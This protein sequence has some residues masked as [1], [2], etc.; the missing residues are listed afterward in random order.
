MNIFTK[1]LFGILILAIC[2]V[3]F[4]IVWQKKQVNTVV[5]S[6]E[7]LEEK[8]DELGVDVNTKLPSN[9]PKPSS[10]NT[11]VEQ[12]TK[13]KSNLASNTE[14]PTV[15]LPSY[16]T[17]AYFENILGYVS[18]GVSTYCLHIRNNSLKKNDTLTLIT[19]GEPQKT[20]KITIDSKA[21]REED[22][23][24]N[25]IEDDQD[26][27]SGFNYKLVSNSDDR[28]GIAVLSKDFIFTQKDNFVTTDLNRNGNYEFYSTCSG[29]EGIN[30]FAWTG[31]PWKSK[32]LWQFYDYAGYDIESTCPDTKVEYAS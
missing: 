13:Q 4:G 6:P 22:C 14:N 1:V 21:L 23:P 19:L 29:T 27:A 31:E 9:A 32:I 30:F 7:P 15:S 10:S 20:Y 12:K 17:G 18:A 11:L 5:K 3:G 16:D 2:A 25:F 24:H 8:Q 26:L 28:D